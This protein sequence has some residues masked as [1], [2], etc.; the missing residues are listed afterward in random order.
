MT[1]RGV[2]VRGDRNVTVRAPEIANAA[3]CTAD[4]EGRRIACLRDGRAVLVEF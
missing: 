1:A 4:D 2:I 3:F